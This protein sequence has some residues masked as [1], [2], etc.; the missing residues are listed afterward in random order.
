MVPII[1]IEMVEKEKYGVYNG[2]ISLAIAV[3]FILGPIR[4]G[5][6]TDGT[7]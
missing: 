2:I 6:I 7:T 1:V 5:A 3:S 4:G